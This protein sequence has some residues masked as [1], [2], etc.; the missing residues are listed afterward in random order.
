MMII[1]KSRKSKA[2]IGTI[3]PRDQLD[4]AWLKNVRQLIKEANMYMRDSDN[5][6]RLY[7]KLRGIN[8]TDVYVYSR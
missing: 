5:D 8:P 3:D 1:D 6:K 4:K 2:Y 7:V